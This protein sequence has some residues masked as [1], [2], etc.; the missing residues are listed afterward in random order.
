MKNNITNKQRIQLIVLLIVSGL[1]SAL[2][3]VAQNTVTDV[4]TAENLGVETSYKTFSDKKLESGACYAGIAKRRPQPLNGFYEIFLGVD[5]NA[6][7]YTTKSSGKIR[8]ISVNWASSGTNSNKLYVYGSNTP[9]ASGTATGDTRLGTLTEGK[10][11]LTATEDYS[12]VRIVPVEKTAYV[13]S[14][15]IKWELSEN[16]SKKNPSLA[17]DSNEYKAY[18]DDGNFDKATLAM[19]DGINGDSITYTSSNEDVAVVESGGDVVLKSVGTTTITAKFAGNTEFNS[20]EASYTLNVVERKFAFDKSSMT[21]TIG[22]TNEF[23]V[24]TNNYD[25]TPT[26]SSSD[27][28]VATVD[29]EGNVTLL[30]AG[31]TKISA[32]L[33]EKDHS[34]S[35]TLTVVEPT[36]VE[37]K[38]YVYKRVTSQDELIDGGIY[39]VAD[40]DTSKVPNVMS[41]NESSGKFVSVSLSVDNDIITSEK[42]NKSGAPYEVTLRKRT[43]GYYLLEFD[44]GK[45]LK[46]PGNAN[47]LAAKSYSSGDDT[48]LWAL[49]YKDSIV[50]VPNKYRKKDGI[51]SEYINTYYY[52]GYNRNEKYF[53]AYYDNSMFPITFYRR[54]GTIDVKTSEGYGTYYSDSAFVMPQGLEG[55]T[56]TGVGVDGTLTMPWEY[57]AGSKVPK[58]TGLLVKGEKA[59][60]M[61]SVLND[62][63]KATSENLLMG[64]AQEEQI[65]ADDNM[66]YY[67]LSYSATDTD[68]KKLGFYWGA[69]NGGSFK[70]GANKAYL[71]I[72][73][74]RSENVQGFSFGSGELTGIEEITTRPDGQSS[75]ESEVYTLAGVRLNCA[76]KDLSSGVYIVNGKKVMIK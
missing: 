58:G 37:A 3:V 19:A 18:I 21:A 53:A 2:K 26:W 12:Y 64:S 34:D 61:Y 15:S 43:S 9:Y 75:A 1:F 72:P 14:I 52:I 35:Y 17:F 60:Y 4:L 33:K 6:C 68:G 54:I 7:I 23:P 16:D 42:A 46:A 65:E 73:K 67:M 49:T 25:E 13:Y 20:G 57:K 5:D 39:L 50:L 30:S 69:E 66:Y 55:T 31:I 10:K 56:V 51:G 38:A 63:T 32:E 29:S 11:E 24:L 44:N 8:S 45:Y 76:V 74:G 48:F 40:T 36:V 47:G 70:N 59:S 41:Y 28:N 71:A 62:T 27:E 22:G